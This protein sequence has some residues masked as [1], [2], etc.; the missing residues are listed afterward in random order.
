MSDWKPVTA[1]IVQ[2]SGI[3]PYLFSI[4]AMGHKCISSYSNI[5]KYADNTILL[6]PQNSPV[7]LEEEF[8][9]IIDWSFNNKLTVNTSKTEEILSSVALAFQINSLTPSTS[10]S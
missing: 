9:H 3:G 6:V 7:S 5:L 10:S 4:Y 2:G 1:S 8:Q